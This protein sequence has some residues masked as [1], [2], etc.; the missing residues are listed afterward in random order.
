MR[1]PG[2]RRPLGPLSAQFRRRA[3]PDRQHQQESGHPPH[4]NPHESIPGAHYPPSPAW[5]VSNQRKTPVEVGTTPVVQGAAA[6]ITVRFA[7]TK[8]NGPSGAAGAIIRAFGP[9]MDRSTLRFLAGR[10]MSRGQAGI[11]CDSAKVRGHSVETELVAL[12][13]LHHEARLVVA[14]GRQ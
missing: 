6:G 4:Q 2:R 10:L 11:G 9:T 12:D 1:P 3:C 14:I 13:V 7:A 8:I 5:L